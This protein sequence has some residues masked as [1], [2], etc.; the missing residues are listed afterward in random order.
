MEKSWI[1]QPG[2]GI[3]KPADPIL[4]RPGPFDWIDDSI[5]IGKPGGTGPHGGYDG[6]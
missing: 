6:L 3:I 2:D 1:K 4:P 5:L